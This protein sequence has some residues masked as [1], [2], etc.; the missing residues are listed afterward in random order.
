MRDVLIKQILCWL[1]LFFLAACATTK[2]NA[3]KEWAK[4]EKQADAVRAWNL[5]GRMAVS[6]PDE[7]F[8]ANIAWKKHQSGQSINIYNSLGNSYL[9]LKQVNKKQPFKVTLELRD[10]KIINGQTVE[11]VMSQVVS[12]PLPIHLLDFWIRGLTLT[13]AENSEL[14]Y[15]D[16]G[17]LNKQVYRNWVIEYSRY[18]DFNEKRLPK[19]LKIVHKDYS[20]KLSIRKWFKQS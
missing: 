10:G 7:S 2:I 9:K 17:S 1:C 3:P 15:N 4:H 8:T 13:N 11:E 20:L 19:R 5:F 12:W 14:L 16:D 6:T 18:A